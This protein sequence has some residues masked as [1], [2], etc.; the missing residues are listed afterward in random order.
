[1]PAARWS[2]AFAE[3]FEHRLVI[4]ARQVAIRIGAADTARTARPHPS[5]RRRR[6]RR[7]AGR[8]YRAAPCGISTRSSRPSRT[9]R[10]RA[11][12]SISSSR[13]RAKSRPFGTRPSEC[14][15]RPTRCRNV[16][17]ERGVPSWQ[18]RSMWPM[19][20]PSSSDAVATTAFS[21]PAFEPLLGLLPAAMRQA[22][23]MATAP[24]LRRA[25]R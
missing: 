23:V 22:A 15:A 17:I 2:D 11:R 1:M 25:A 4:L 13:L 8:E 7:S 5:R 20:M 10:T 12:H 16:A 19:S 14:P 9:A 18:T 24:G 6:R 3:H 21:S